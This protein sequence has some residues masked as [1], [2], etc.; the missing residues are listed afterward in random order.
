MIVN[1]RVYFRMNTTTMVQKSDGMYAMTMDALLGTR[2]LGGPFHDIDDVL[3]ACF[4]EMTVADRSADA[5]FYV[6]IAKGQVSV[7]TFPVG[8]FPTESEVEAR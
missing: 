2:E 6:E 4:E 1:D 3:D 7:R 8:A 5:M